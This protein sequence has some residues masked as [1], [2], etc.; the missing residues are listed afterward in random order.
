M[1]LPS[2]VQNSLRLGRDLAAE[3]PPHQSEWRAW[4]HLRPVLDGPDFDSVQ[5]ERNWD[6][7]ATRYD[8]APVRF[9]LRRVE[10]SPWHLREEWADD[11]DVAMSQRPVPDETRVVDTEAD[12][13]AALAEWGVDPEALRLPVTVDYPEPPPA[14]GASPSAV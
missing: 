5:E 1:S 11:L 9:V 12:V 4:V 8:S 6:R 3:A 2:R 7:V 10:L 13:L 14:L